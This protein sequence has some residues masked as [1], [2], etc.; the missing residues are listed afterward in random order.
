MITQPVTIS[1]ETYTTILEK[2]GLGEPHTTLAGAEAWYPEDAARERDVRVLHELRQQGLAVGNR[3]SEDFY[4]V[5]VTM[6][7]P[8]V[9]YYTYYRPPDGGRANARTARI[10][11]DAILITL[12]GTSVRVEPI[13]REQLGVRLAAAL[14]ETPAARVQ[15]INCDGADVL[16]L[17]EDKPLPS[18]ATASEAKRMKRWLDLQRHTV[19]QLFAAIRD[20]QGPATVTKAPLSCW[21]DTDSG[22]MLLCPG[23][24][25]WYTLRAGDLMSIANHL[26]DLEQRLRT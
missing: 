3:V 5:L 10:G 2:E 14:P 11:R 21:I 8:A 1:L 15:A 12:A 23:T 18:G 25:G 16:A 4:D 7:R 22:R 17:A 20:G 19:G 6:Q 24:N 13:P 26:S 9:E